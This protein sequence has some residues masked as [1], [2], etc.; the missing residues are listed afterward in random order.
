MCGISGAHNFLD[1]VP[2]LAM[3]PHSR[4]ELIMFF[5]SPTSFIIFRSVFHSLFVLINSIF[6]IFKCV[7][8]LSLL[9]HKQRFLRLKVGDVIVILDFVHDLSF[10]ENK[11]TIII[12]RTKVLSQ[13]IKVKIDFIVNK[14]IFLLVFGVIAIIFYTISSYLGSI[15]TAASTWDHFAFL[16]VWAQI[17]KL[18]LIIIRLHF[19]RCGIW[20]NR[21]LLTFASCTSL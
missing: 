20:C 21:L 17:F 2:V 16:F 19:I 7:I 4:Q 9:F 18:P 10:F 5:S 12:S 8:I 1:L 15:V 14:V 6:I 11:L 3:H 13:Y